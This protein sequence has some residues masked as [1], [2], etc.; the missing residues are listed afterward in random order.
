MALIHSLSS[1][2]RHKHKRPRRR[3]PGAFDE[4]GL[5]IDGHHETVDE[6]LLDNRGGLRHKCLLTCCVAQQPYFDHNP[7]AEGRTAEFREVRSKESHARTTGTGLRFD[8]RFRVFARADTGTYSGAGEYRSRKAGRNGAREIDFGSGQHARCQF[9]GSR[10]ST[11]SRERYGNG[12]RIERGLAGRK[13]CQIQ[14]VEQLRTRVVTGLTQ[15]VRVRVGAGGLGPRIALRVREFAP[16]RGK[17]CEP[18]ALCDL[19]G[20]LRVD[21]GGAVASISAVRVAGKDCAVDRAAHIGHAVTEKD[22]CHDRYRRGFGSGM[23][24]RYGM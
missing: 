12:R 9:H 10:E 1:R 19:C 24:Q 11:Q 21:R 23:A 3:L 6:R 4:S 7:G 20:G 16:C 22:S 18:S 8:F 17:A 14:F 5:N 2:Q 13:Q 15:S